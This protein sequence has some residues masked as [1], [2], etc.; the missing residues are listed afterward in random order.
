MSADVMLVAAVAE[1]GVIGRDGDMPWRLSTDLK[2][3]KALTLGKPMI[4][5][6]KTFESIGKALPGRDTVVVTRSTD[7]AA[8]GVLVAHSLDEALVVAQECA[9]T[10]GADEIAI[11]GGGDIYAQAMPLATRLHITHVH[12]S[13]DGD[14][15]FPQI[16]A[17]EW[18]ASHTEDV[19]AGERDTASTRYVVYERR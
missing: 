10:R 11:V 7:F 16:D 5:G 12:A 9:A 3:F 8:D 17:A 6:R 18:A 15:I 4:M 14:T 13:P 2:R 19:P 1:N